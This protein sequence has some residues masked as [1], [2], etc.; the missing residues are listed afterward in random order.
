MNPLRSRFRSRSRSTTGAV[1][2]A[3][4]FAAFLALGP[5]IA[6]AQN[7]AV[8]NNKAIP[9]AKA[10]AVIA[11][12]VK[13]GQQ[14]SP[15]LQT[16]V[17]ED[18]V[19]REILMQEADK[20]GLAAD[21]DV[22]AQ[23]ER[24]R[25]Q[26]LIGALAQD[27]FKANPPTDAD[28]RAQYDVLV[29]ETGGKEYKARHILVEKEAD[30]KAIIAKLKAGA[31]FEDLAKQSK[32]PGSAANGG[33][34]DWAPASTYVKEF[35]DALAKLPKGQTTQVPVKTNFGYHV[36]RL[37]DVRDAKVPTFE[38]AKPQIA[39]AMMANQQWQQGRF[40]Q[41]MKDLRDKAKVE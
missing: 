4:L 29:K 23:L 36:I 7:V 25:Q 15:E 35:G 38:E 2:I 32:D 26:V 11:Q 30:A 13:Q 22:Q 39:S 10:D 31:K 21:P 40:E 1:A 27:Y 20:K 28:I 18:L 14:D 6:T 8:V 5:T 3:A 16:A 24:A 12:L 41:M 33:E 17:R 9:K 34:L 19:R 37:D